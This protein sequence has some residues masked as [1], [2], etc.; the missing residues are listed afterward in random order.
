MAISQGE[1]VFQVVSNV[2]DVESGNAVPLPSQWTSKQKDEVYGG[3]FQMFKSGETQHKGSPNDAQL[4]KYIPGLVNNWVRKDK[5]L[6]GGTKYVAKNPGSRTGSGDE[7]L[8]EMKKLLSLIK[9]P[10]QRELVQTAIEER[11]AAIKPKTDPL[12][13]TKLPESLRHLVVQ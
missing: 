2:F 9:D 1:A 8:R 3:V 7:Q 6:N 13:V 4:L 11:V 10:A 5:R 12:D